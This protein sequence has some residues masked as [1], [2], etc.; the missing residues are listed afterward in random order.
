MMKKTKKIVA[1]L[2]SL[3]MCGSIVLTSGCD[4]LG[5]G[6]SSS[7][8]QSEGT[9]GDDGE[10]AS[11]AEK[12]SVY[13][14]LLNT[15]TLFT[16]AGQ[17]VKIT[18]DV[19]VEG[20]YGS[21][22]TDN[23]GASADI[24]DIG[25][26]TMTM[27]GAAYYKY[28][29]TDGPAI[30]ATISG[31]ITPSDESYMY[32]AAYLRGKGVYLGSETSATAIAPSDVVFMETNVET[33]LAMLASQMPM[34]VE[35]EEAGSSF[36][37][38][39]MGAMFKMVMPVASKLASSAFLGLGLTTKTQGDVTTVT[40]NVK[41][42]MALILAM[43]KAMANTIDETTT[44]ADLLANEQLKGLFN[45]Y[46]GGMSAE[47]LYALITLAASVSGSMSQEMI[48]TMF[49]A[50]ADDVA[51]YDYL[52]SVLV[53]LPYDDSDSTIG[54]VV[55]GEKAKTQIL[56]SVAEMETTLA[57]LNKYKISFQI[58]GGVLSQFSLDFDQTNA[59]K[60]AVSVGIVAVTDYDFVDVTALNTS[61]E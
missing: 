4:L 16:T 19:D 2:L 36:D 29:A 38:E 58:K 11:V 24:I 12:T 40:L 51:A 30:D 23:S 54:S 33:L 41:T 49:P 50:P 44:V 35:E 9:S 42:E 46:L 14:S 45:Q 32:A 56:T 15:A 7:G 28:D 57:Q 22:A 48:A 8:S 52:V 31:V 6:N 55:V 13:E 61:A 10:K 17:T 43:V 20:V 27:D 26:G 3:L 47:D 21:K 1:S 5:G 18:L 34:E 60:V 39:A 37:A 25:V 53:A 59:G